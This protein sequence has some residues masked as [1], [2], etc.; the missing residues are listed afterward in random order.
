MSINRRFAV[1][2]FKVTGRSVYTS[3]S[4]AD[5]FQSASLRGI[6]MSCKHINN[7]ISI[8][9]RVI[10]RSKTGLCKRD[11]RSTKAD[12][13][14]ELTTVYD[15]FGKGER[16]F[17]YVDYVSKRKKKIRLHV[18][19]VIRDTKRLFNNLKY[20]KHVSREYL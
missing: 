10:N 11:C 19:I 18:Q 5:R 2:C 1:H 4:F 15:I 13:R 7:T 20:F 8:R 12:R 16:P 6:G 14:D 3:I 17:V 9:T